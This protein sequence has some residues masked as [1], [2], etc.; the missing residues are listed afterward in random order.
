MRTFFAEV[1]AVVPAED[2]VLLLG[3]GE[4]VEHFAR[5][6]T[7][8]DHGRAGARRIQIEK[9]GPMTEPQLLARIRAYAGVPA[10]RTLPS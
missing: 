6:I 1:G 3:D 9:S 7:A 8:R 5:Q 2:D 4:V 10:R